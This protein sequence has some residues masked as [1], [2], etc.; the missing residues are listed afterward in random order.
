[1]L[2]QPEKPSKKTKKRRKSSFLSTSSKHTQTTFSN[3][4]KKR[5]RTEQRLDAPEVKLAAR[6]KRGWKIAQ[7]GGALGDWAKLEKVS[8]P[9]LIQ[10]VLIHNQSLQKALRQNARI[11]GAFTKADIVFR[12]KLLV[13]IKYDKWTQKQA[14]DMMRQTPAALSQ[15]KRRA[16]EKDDP[17]ELLILYIPEKEF[18]RFISQMKLFVSIK[19]RKKVVVDPI[20]PKKTHPRLTHH[21]ASKATIDQHPRLIDQAEMDRRYATRAARDVANRISS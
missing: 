12:L 18:D 3:R 2:T 16:L 14:A 8:K 1:M 7:K 21:R 20:S 13:G 15:W 19:P 11:G 10:K 6:L 9:Y 4:T 17:E 5:H